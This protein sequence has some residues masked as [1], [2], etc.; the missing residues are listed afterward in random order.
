TTAMDDSISLV[1]VIPTEQLNPN[2]LS[3]VNLRSNVAVGLG[4][5]AELQ[6]NA[7]YNHRAT[8][9]LG[10]GFNNAYAAAF[11]GAGFFVLP[12]QPY[13][14]AG[15]DQYFS[16]TSTERVSRFFGSVTGRW[17]PTPWLLLRASG[18]VDLASIT[19]SSLVRRRDAPCAAFGLFN[20]GAVGDDRGDQ[21]ATTGELLATA[22]FS[23]S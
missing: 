22:S 2:A 14:A 20:L 16:R 11:G 9:T 7:G 18:G 1:R 3:A 21:R 19:R 23:S 4:K 8:R 10:G 13:G 17:S 15:P 5:T 6:V 12:G